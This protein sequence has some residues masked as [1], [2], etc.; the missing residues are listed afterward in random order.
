M[1]SINV[2]FAIIITCENK[3]LMAIATYYVKGNHDLYC[4]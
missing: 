2:N 3:N 4:A 1:Y